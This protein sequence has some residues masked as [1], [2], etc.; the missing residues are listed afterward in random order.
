MMSDYHYNQSLYCEPPN[1]GSIH[2]P[3]IFFN[4]QT[5]PIFT[6]DGCEMTLSKYAYS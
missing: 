3:D 4:K 2:A 1:T 6:T 5:I